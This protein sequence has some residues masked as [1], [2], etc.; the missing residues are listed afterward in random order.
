MNT[1]E[2][3]R[4]GDELLN[5]SYGVKRYAVYKRCPRCRTKNNLRQPQTNVCYACTMKEKVGG[6]A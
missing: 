5:A 2:M 6:A 3:R 1:A 4:R